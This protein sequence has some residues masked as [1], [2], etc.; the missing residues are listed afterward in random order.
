MTA[1]GP[2]FLSVYSRCVSESG[3]NPRHLVLEITKEVFAA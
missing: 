3:I 2:D 1:E